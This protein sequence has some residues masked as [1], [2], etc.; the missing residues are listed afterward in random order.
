MLKKP[1]NGTLI[2]IMR[3]WDKDTFTLNNI[4]EFS[5]HSYQ[6]ESMR[7]AEHGG[8]NW[9]YTET[10]LLKKFQKK[11]KNFIYYD[12]I[13]TVYDPDDID[14]NRTCLVKNNIKF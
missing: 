6:A 4:V 14:F 13:I 1:F 3:R 12:K 10:R 2:G 5:P 11:K 8:P 9:K 7:K